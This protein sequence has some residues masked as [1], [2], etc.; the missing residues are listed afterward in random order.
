MFYM[1]K[2][3]FTLIELLV[4]IAIIGI[5]AGIVL[6]SLGT[7]RTKANDS[8]IKSQLNSARTASAEQF[9]LVNGSYGTQGTNNGTAG[10]NCGTTVAATNSTLF[11]DTTF[12]MASL[13][14]SVI[15]AA[16]ATTNSDCGVTPSGAGA[17]NAWSIAV[18]LPGGGIWCVDS[19]GVAR[20]TQSGGSAYTG[21]S[22]GGLYGAATAAHTAAGASVCN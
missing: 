19:T 1:N 10:S 13:I 8:K 15:T 14:S 7:A 18:A 5:L 4:V 12:N 21:G 22:V 2:R 3:G 16:G 17:A 6:A 9:Y 20:S 11:S